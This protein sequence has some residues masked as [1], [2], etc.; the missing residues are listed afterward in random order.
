M[1]TIGYLIL[2]FNIGLCFVNVMNG[3]Y[4]YIPLNIAGAVLTILGLSIL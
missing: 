3:K 1:K 4:K 2:A